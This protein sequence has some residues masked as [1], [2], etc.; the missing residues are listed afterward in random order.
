MYNVIWEI[1]EYSTSENYL[2]ETDKMYSYKY[3]YLTYA[4]LKLSRVALIESLSAIS[5]A[6][7]I[8]P[9]DDFALWYNFRIFSKLSTPEIKLN[10]VC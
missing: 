8:S 6:E 1:R 10:I 3:N 2:K 4:S 5:N 7:S 9:K